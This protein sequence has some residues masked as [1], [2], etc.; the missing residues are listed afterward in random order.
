MRQD[1]RD[2]TS[3]LDATFLSLNKYLNTCF[4]L[5]HLVGTLHAAERALSKDVVKVRCS[6]EQSEEK[7]E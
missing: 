5:L 6:K 4:A 3:K 7:G 1:I 2:Q